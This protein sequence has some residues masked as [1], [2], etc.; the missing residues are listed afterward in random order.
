MLGADGVLRMFLERG[1][2]VLYLQMPLMGDN[3][4]PRF[5][6]SATAS[7][8]EQLGA[9]RK[10]GFN[11]LIAFVHP[12]RIA[13]NYARRQQTFTDVS[14]L[15]IS[16]GGWTTTVYTAVDPGVVNS[17]P[18]AGS[19]PSSMLHRSDDPCPH[20]VDW[21]QRQFPLAALNDDPGQPLGYLDLYLMGST[22]SDGGPA[23][24]QIQVLNRYDPCCFT[25]A[26]VEGT[27]ETPLRDFMA[28]LGGSYR[29]AIDATH[30][31]HRISECALTSIVLP[32]LNGVTPRTF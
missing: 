12:V 17:F 23:R 11:P 14:M 13:I 26:K 7:P 2:T 19:L 5:E 21:E 10:A 16:G 18:V 4:D 6:L 29:L 15:G 3:A 24:Q 1:Y 22:R 20:D 25:G 32:A 30:I 9:R 8:H 31:D 28:G 27:F